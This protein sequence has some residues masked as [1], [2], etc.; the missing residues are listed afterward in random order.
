MEIDLAV[1]ADAANVTIE[2]KVNLI[3]IF[4]N[5]LAQTLPGTLPFFYIA[6]TITPSRDE[7]G[8]SHNFEIYFRRANED[9]SSRIA[10]GGFMTQ[11][12]PEYDYPM[13]NI[14]VGV[15]NLQV[16]EYGLYS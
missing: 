10:A 5:F 6:F 3:G 9:Q 2:N 16:A 15:A 13:L 12:Q 4:R 7:L 14:L 1:L 11:R 8:I